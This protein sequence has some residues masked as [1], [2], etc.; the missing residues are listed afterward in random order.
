MR[1]IRITRMDY[2]LF[3]NKFLDKKIV[4]SQRKLNNLKK[5]IVL[6]QKIYSNVKLR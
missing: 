2:K 4:T 3:V 5:L 1:I 6:E